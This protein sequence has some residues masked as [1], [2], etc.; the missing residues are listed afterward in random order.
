MSRS[1]FY[2]FQMNHKV[3]KMVEKL[4]K[5]CH[6]LG[7]VYYEPSRCFEIGYKHVRAG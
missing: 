4:Q 1:I 2:F 5:K 6:I 3:V 7:G